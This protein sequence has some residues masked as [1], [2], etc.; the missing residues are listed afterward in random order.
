MYQVLYRKWRPRTF[1]EVV[2]QPQV[3]DTLK[4][5]ICSGRLAHAYLFV[6]SRGTG[7]TTCAKILSRAVNCL[8]P[9]G[10]D[11]CG[12]CEICRGIDSGSIFDVVEIDAASNNGVDN[13]RELRTEASFTPARAKYRVY[14]IDEVHMLS[15]GAFNAL[16]KTLEEPPEH[17]IFILATTEV[18]KLPA[19]I[20]SRC[21]R[22]DFRRIT[23]EDIA[24][25]LMEV[26]GEEHIPLTEPAALLIG[27]LAD[28]ALR[29]ALSLLDRCAVTEEEL[30]EGTV[31]KIAGVAGRDYLFALSEAIA[32]HD[33]AAALQA[34]DRLHA[35][36]VDMRR[37]CE[38]LIGH[39]RNLMLIKVAGEP[40][41]L[42]ICSD[43]DYARMQ[44]TAR[45]F[46]ADEI[47]YIVT[48]C[49]ACLDRLGRVMN[50]RSE[51]EI[52][53][54][55]LCAGAKETKQDM[56]A[57][58]ARIGRLEQALAA[59]VPA[60]A[61]RPMEPEKMP[62]PEKT[63]EPAEKLF[64]QPAQ[65]AAPVEGEAPPLPEPPPLPEDAPAP[66]KQRA[67]GAPGR[68]MLTEWGQA[69]DRIRSKNLL[70]YSILESSSAYEMGERLLIDSKSSNFSVMIR[71]GN[72]AE[73]IR[74]ALKEVTGR[75]YRLAIYKQPQAQPKKEPLNDLLRRA[76][77]AGVPVDEV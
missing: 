58:S 36:S 61:P 44:K 67:E 10:G 68:R 4:H 42:I 41:G 13:I 17:V 74:A 18:H 31:A 29:D 24:G 43:G 11:P 30:T 62:E 34:V 73:T 8:H 7:K 23:P 26:A 70:L 59:G 3:T 55:R 38:E 2:G 27:R 72:Y 50:R 37:L 22:F 28:G 1:S 25:R 47:L 63:P 57:L 39:F 21:Q 19:T 33:A 71:Q 15:A 6:G 35:D 76:G 77:E 48:E 56:A 60:A 45:S 64:P 49:A 66:Q 51:M 40:R 53:L 12:E 65:K 16:L 14:I 54:I 5:E 52:L 9:E 20:L 46:S 32:A 75:D 69:L